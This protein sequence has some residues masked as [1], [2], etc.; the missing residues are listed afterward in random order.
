MSHSSS[1]LPLHSSH[2][3]VARS[4]GGCQFV[5]QIAYFMLERLR[6]TQSCQMIFEDF[7]FQDFFCYRVMNYFA[8]C[9]YI[10]ALGYFVQR[11]FKIHVCKPDSK[12]ANCLCHM[13]IVTELS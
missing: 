7:E 1:P 2:T 11:G 5:A 9:S 6:Q 3:A 13:A 8:T 10:L 12:R 4:T